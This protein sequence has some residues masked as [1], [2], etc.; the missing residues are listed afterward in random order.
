MINDVLDL[1]KIESGRREFKPETVA[2]RDVVAEI[3]ASLG[4]LA[5]EKGLTF[6]VSVA[7][8]VSTL[9]T[10]RRALHQI[11]LNLASNAIKFTDTGSVRIEARAAP[12]DGKPGVAVSVTD[13]GIGIKREDLQ[14]LFIAFEQLDPT[15]ARRFEGTGL[16]LH[17]SRNLATLIGGELHVTSEFGFGSTFTLLVPVTNEAS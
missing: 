6:A 15:S 13:T 8:D 9:V 14:R 5:E 4:P 2:L 16:G 10:D 7:G 11:L 3:G 17:L 1:A 12:C